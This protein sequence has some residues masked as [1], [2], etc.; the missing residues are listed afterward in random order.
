MLITFHEV[1]I[2]VEAE[3]PRAA[4]L[5]LQEALSTD[6]IEYDTF[7][8]STEENGVVKST[9]ALWELGDSL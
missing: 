6:E 8:Y 3:T 9:Q 4:Y 7:N 1:D 5:K 2:F